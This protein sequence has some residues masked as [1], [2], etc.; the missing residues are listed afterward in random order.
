MMMLLIMRMMMFAEEGDA[1]QH[2]DD[3]DD[4]DRTRKSISR[5]CYG[6]CPNAAAN[7]D[8][9]IKLCF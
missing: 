6:S 1:A 8:S 9:L 4:A 2:T 3:I 5:F 7:T